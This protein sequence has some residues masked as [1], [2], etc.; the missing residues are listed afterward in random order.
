MR[1]Y[2][3]APGTVCGTM[4]TGVTKEG[5]RRESKGTGDGV[6]FNDGYTLD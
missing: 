2:L 4:E 5:K 6:H 3:F 1:E